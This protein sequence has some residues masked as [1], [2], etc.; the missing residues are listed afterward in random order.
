MAYFS[1]LT[2][3]VTCNLTSILERE[4]DPTRAIGEI[5]DEMREGVDGAHRSAGTAEQNVGRLEGEIAEQRNCIA[6]WTDEAKRHL[7]AGD[8]D[9]ARAALVRRRECQDVVAG[10]E[11]ELGN[12][13]ATR[14]HLRTTVK[15]LEA[16]L[17][18][19]VRRQHELGSEGTVRERSAA[20]KHDEAAA[21]R[22][23]SEEIDAELETLKRALGKP[24]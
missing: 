9:L 14:D 12:A 1:R 7:E 16:R 11:Q 22:G 5:V 13:I 24:V 21:R 2:E 19:A 18:D 20:A 17:A 6:E 8:E 23:C 15:A 4:A 3:I 10:L